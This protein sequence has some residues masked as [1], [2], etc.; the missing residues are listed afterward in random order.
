MKPVLSPKANRKKRYKKMISVLLVLAVLLTLAYFTAGRQGITLPEEILQV[1]VAPVQGVFQR[2]TRSVEG[3]FATVKNY[4]LLLAENEQLRERLTEA[5]TLEARLTELRKENNRLRQML[6]LREALSFDL[7]AAE[8]IARDPSSW[9][10]T[11]TINKGT[12]DGVKRN[13]AVV[14]TDGLAGKILSVSATTSNVQLLTDA[15]LSVSALVQRSRETGEVG[16]VENEPTNPEFLRIIDLPRDA[17]ILAGDTVLSSGLGGVFPKGLVI[18]YVVE[19]RV[20]DSGLTRIA[21]LQPAAKFNRLEEVFIVVPQAEPQ[22]W[23]GEVPQ[24]GEES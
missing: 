4:Q 15:R 7:I 13:M 23:P 18:G 8:V 2:L 21:T 1:V 10:N 16:R 3:V 11:V 20:S 6:D 19:S 5:V 17:N 22:Y 12:K 24:E 14:T 9:F